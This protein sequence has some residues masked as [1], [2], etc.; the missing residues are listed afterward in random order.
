MKQRHTG[1][2][3]KREVDAVLV[4]QWAEWKAKH[5][6]QYET[7]AE[8]ARRFALFQENKRRVDEHNEKFAKGEVAY[9]MGLNAFS[10][11]VTFVSN[12]LMFIY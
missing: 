3:P 12:G 2:R 11:L 5:N 1:L 8:E 7:P 10:D 9:S 6:K 4:Q